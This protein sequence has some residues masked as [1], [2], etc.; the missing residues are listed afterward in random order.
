[1]RE[2]DDGRLSHIPQPWWVLAITVNSLLIHNRQ[3][4]VD[5]ARSPW[6]NSL[7]R[8]RGFRPNL[9]PFPGRVEPFWGLK[10]PWEGIDGRLGLQEAGN[11]L[12]NQAGPENTGRY[13]PR[14]AAYPMRACRATAPTA[15]T[16]AG[17]SLRINAPES[18]RCLRRTRTHAAP[19][20][21]PLRRCPQWC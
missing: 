6:C 17:A 3:Q 19:N 20:T 11:A 14:A 10:P 12:H 9:D 13:P 21:E 1:M 18:A 15:S 5:E 16:Y 8:L 7:A 2:Q 4:S